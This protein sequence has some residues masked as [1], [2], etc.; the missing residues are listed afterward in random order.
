MA[1]VSTWQGTDALELDDGTVLL[2]HT[3]KDIDLPPVDCW[4]TNP[5]AAPCTVA[6]AMSLAPTH[7][8]W[9]TEHTR[10]CVRGHATSMNMWIEEG[11]LDVAAEIAEAAAKLLRQLHD[12]TDPERQVSGIAT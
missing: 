8:D 4:I 1:Y 5:D 6:E 2:L 3:T 10:E 7:A 9:I 11:Y 12:A